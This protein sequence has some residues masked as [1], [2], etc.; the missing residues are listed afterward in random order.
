LGVSCIFAGSA[1]AEITGNQLKEYCQFYPAQTQATAACIGY[2]TGSLD[3]IR[4]M[5]K[6][7]KLKAACEPP[8]VTGEQLASMTVK[9]LND[10]PADLH[11]VAASLILNLYTKSFPCTAK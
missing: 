5:S 11:F 6:M 8:G 4:G 3:T 9:Y 7:L 2:I 10:N 1:S